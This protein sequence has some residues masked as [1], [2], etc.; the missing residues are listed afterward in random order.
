MI[1]QVTVEDEAG[2]RQVYTVTAQ[3]E[4]EAKMLVRETYPWAEF[5]IKVER[6]EV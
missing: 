5:V 6:I 3:S 2:F 4:T 1:W